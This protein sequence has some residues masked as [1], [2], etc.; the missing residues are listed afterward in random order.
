MAGLFRRLFGHFGHSHRRD[1]SAKK[2]AE[3]VKQKVPS[4][5]PKEKVH[6][7]PQRVESP[8]RQ[9]SSGPVVSRCTYGNGGVQVPSA[10][11]SPPDYVIVDYLLIA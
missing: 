11:L 7:Q 6:V 10:L 4:F 2:A 9:V 3:K 1:E 8:L 5:R